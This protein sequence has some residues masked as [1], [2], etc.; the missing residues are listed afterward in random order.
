MAI[1][2]GSVPPSYAST[3]LTAIITQLMT[4]VENTMT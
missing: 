2:S 3:L 1:L 4:P